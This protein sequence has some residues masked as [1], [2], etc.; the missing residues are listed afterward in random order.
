[1]GSTKIRQGTCPRCRAK[2]R[3]HVR[4]FPDIGELGDEEGNLPDWISLEGCLMVP[5]P[6]FDRS[7]EACGLRWSSRDQPR[8]IFVTWRDVLAYLEVE[9][10]EQANEW[11]RDHIWPTA[12]ISRFPDLHDAHG[13]VEVLNGDLHKTLHFPLLH[14]EWQSALLD[15]FDDA[16]ERN[17]GV[18]DWPWGT[19]D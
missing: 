18:P 1:M 16:V 6:S 9:S 11:L 2:A 8:A 7:C 13:N 19:T 14:A 4:G 12:T 15:I 17:D 3:H 10:N 5:G